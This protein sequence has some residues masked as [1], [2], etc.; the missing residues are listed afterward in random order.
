MRTHSTR[1]ASCVLVEQRIGLRVDDVGV[2]GAQRV[3]PSTGAAGLLRIPTPGKMVYEARRRGEALVDTVVVHLIMGA[4][5]PKM[6]QWL[7]W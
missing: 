7:H 1:D 4:I 2:L 6:I 3:G 5:L